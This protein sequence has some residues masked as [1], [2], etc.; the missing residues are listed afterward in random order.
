MLLNTH[1]VCGCAHLVAP[2]C[3]PSEMWPHRDQRSAPPLCLPLAQLGTPRGGGSSARSRGAFPGV[4][5]VQD[6]RLALHDSPGH[7]MNSMNPSNRSM[8]PNSVN[9]SSSLHMGG[10]DRVAASL[11]LPWHAQGQPRAHGRRGGGPGGRG[12]GRGGLEWGWKG[13]QRGAHRCTAPLGGSLG[14]ADTGGRGARAPARRSG[15]QCECCSGRGRGPRGRRRGRGGENWR[16]QAESPGLVRRYQGH[17]GTEGHG[18]EGLG[19]GIERE[20][21]RR[22]DPSSPRRPHNTLGASEGDSLAGHGHSRAL[23]PHPL[24]PPLSR[25]AGDRDGDAGGHSLWAFWG[26]GAREC[27]LRC[28]PP[29][30]P[31]CQPGGGRQLAPRGWLAWACTWAQWGAPAGGPAGE[32]PALITA[33]MPPGF[34]R[35]KVEKKIVCCGGMCIALPLGSSSL[36][37]HSIVASWRAARLEGTFLIATSCLA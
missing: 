25:D 8:N 37:R 35:I 1:S 11:G 27:C 31:L 2:G 30:G 33:L 36:Q 4:P 10:L 29:P 32:K 13:S 20:R 24:L 5:V 34:L 23:E 17:T 7:S 9:T 21:E 26:R 6:P 22:W 18:R 28:Q 15:A 3:S 16:W 12:G 19:R 14:Q